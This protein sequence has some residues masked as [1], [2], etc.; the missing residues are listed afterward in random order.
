MLDIVF[1][2]IGYFVSFFLSMRLFPVLYDN[3]KME[4]V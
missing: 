2:A 3:C 1:T 4:L